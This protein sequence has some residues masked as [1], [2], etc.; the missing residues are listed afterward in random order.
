MSVSTYYLAVSSKAV[1]Q[2]V[3]NKFCTFKA[4][5]KIYSAIKNVLFKITGAVG[6]C[7]CC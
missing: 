4:M 6:A 5:Q 2:N 7:R 1:G 3:H